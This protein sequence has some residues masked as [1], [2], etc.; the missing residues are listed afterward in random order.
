MSDW[1]ANASISLLKRE[2]PRIVAATGLFFHSLEERVDQCSVESLLESYRGGTWGEETTPGLGYPVLRS[3]NMRGAR[4]DISDP[5]WCNVLPQQADANTLQ[6]GDILVTKSSGSSDLVGK[7]AIFLQPEGDDTKYLFSNFT[8]RLRPDQSVV[9][10]EYLAWFLRSP[11]SLAWRFSTQQT[12]VGLRNLQTGEFLGQSVPVPPLEIQ[13]LIVKYLNALER[14]DR[15][16]FELKLPAYLD[17]QRRLVARIEALAAKIEEA[18]G[19]RNDVEKD[20]RKLLLSVYTRLIKGAQYLLM[21]DVAPLVRR[22]IRIQVSASYP[23]LGIRS[24]G[25]GTFHKPALEGVL[26]GTK[27]L[28][29][30]EPGDLIFSNVFAWEGA[31]AV[32]QPKDH[33]RFGSHRFITCVPK[34]DVATPEFLCFH[35]LTR[36]GLEDIGDASPGGAG[37]NRTLGLEALSRIRVPIPPLD[38]QKW[39]AEL[40]AKTDVMKQLRAQTQVELDALLPSVLDRAFKGELL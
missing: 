8:L 11:Q 21:E 37:R 29:S 32:S 2:L 31:I 33:D 34:K 27:K 36:K 19:I 14:N 1:L 5:A 15:S 20:T 7:A 10:P 28:F 18:R 39:F 40:L 9:V 23:E 30:I 4:V 13:S 17:E 38:Q 35:F 12:T 16:A 6:T 25:K 22:P 26:V 3:T 24:F